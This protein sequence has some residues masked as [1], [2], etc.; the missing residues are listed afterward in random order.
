MLTHPWAT[1]N[2][3]AMQARCVTFPIGRHEVGRGIRACIVMIDGPAWAVL[4]DVLM[5]PMNIP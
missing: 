1:C 4:S 3:S 5:R 2:H